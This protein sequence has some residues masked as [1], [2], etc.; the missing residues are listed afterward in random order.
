MGKELSKKNN[1]VRRERLI[2]A[3]GA[4]VTGLARLHKWWGAHS[5]NLKRA[6]LGGGNPLTSDADSKITHK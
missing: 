1:K 6:L 5:L 4:R 3:T 2:Q